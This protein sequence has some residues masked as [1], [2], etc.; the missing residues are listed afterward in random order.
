MTCA[1]SCSDMS[2]GRSRPASRIVFMA[3]A[4]GVVEMVYGWDITKFIAAGGVVAVCI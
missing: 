4:R 1:L 2:T 3:S